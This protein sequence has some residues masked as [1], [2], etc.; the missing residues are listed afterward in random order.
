V[1]AD[2]GPWGSVM[3][4]KSEARRQAESQATP[5]RANVRL[6]S[7][8]RPRLDARIRLV[9]RACLPEFL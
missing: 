5:N 4:V 8:H 9:E 1:E 3:V 7:L 6:K 2:R